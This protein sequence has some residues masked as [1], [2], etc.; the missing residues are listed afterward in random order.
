MRILKAFLFSWV[1][2]PLLVNVAV[3]DAKSTKVLLAVWEGAG[4][5]FQVSETNAQFIGTINGQLFVEDDT[6]ALREAEITCPATL[7]IVIADGT[8]NGTGH[9]II[10]TPENE[11]VFARWTCVGKRESGCAGDFQITGGTGQFKGASGQGGLM[12]RSTLDSA[13]SLAIGGT[14]V[15]A[16]RGLMMIEGLTLKKAD[17]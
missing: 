3:A 2:M 15:E 17:N 14:S 12:I 16:A 9:C 5:A 11:R 4:V 10:R 1:A 13:V 7:D 8:Q 6:R